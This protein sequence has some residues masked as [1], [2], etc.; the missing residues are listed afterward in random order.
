MSVKTVEQNERLGKQ[1]T[2]IS[3]KTHKDGLF[4]FST[5]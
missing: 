4:V 2:H 5:A 1:I 3:G